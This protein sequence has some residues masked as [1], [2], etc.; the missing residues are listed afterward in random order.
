MACAE[1]HNSADYA[2]HIKQK[3]MLCRKC[4][5]GNEMWG[6]DVPYCIYYILSGG[7]K[8]TRTQADI[9]A[10]P[11]DVLRK[12]VKSVMAGIHPSNADDA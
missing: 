10:V 3:T 9:G 12:R 5:C 1:S 8:H 11:I 4:E 7:E 2:D 6:D